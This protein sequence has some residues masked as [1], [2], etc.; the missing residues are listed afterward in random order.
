MDAPSAGSTLTESSTG[1]RRDRTAPQAEHESEDD[2][3]NDHGEEEIGKALG[4][5]DGDTSRRIIDTDSSDSQDELL[6]D[7]I[8]E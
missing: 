6:E 1:D 2:E 3:Q 8:L 4:D 7:V 5:H